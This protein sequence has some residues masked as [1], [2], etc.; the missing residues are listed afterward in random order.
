M[1]QGQVKNSLLDG[2]I[3]RGNV[4]NF[5]DNP[6]KNKKSYNQIANIFPQK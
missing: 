5:G 4:S 2:L 3:Q 6:F 1:S